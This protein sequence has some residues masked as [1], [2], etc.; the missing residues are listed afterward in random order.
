MGVFSHQMLDD[1]GRPF[2]PCPRET[3]RDPPAGQLHVS[4]RGAGD[5]DAHRGL[6]CHVLRGAGALCGVEQARGPFGRVVVREAHAA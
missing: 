5:T 1:V 6:R 2:L 4:H 3:W